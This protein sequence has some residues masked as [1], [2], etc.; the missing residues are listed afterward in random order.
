MPV[1]L[2]KTSVHRAIEIISLLDEDDL[3]MSISHLQITKK[4][5]ERFNAL[6]IYS[7]FQLVCAAK[8]H[9]ESELQSRKDSEFERC[10]SYNGYETGQRLKQLASVVRDGKVVWP[11]FWESI[12]YDFTFAA[13]RLDQAFNFDD[14]TNSLTIDTIDIGKAIFSFQDDGIH[15][16]GDLVSRLSDGLPDYRGFG[17]SKMK[18]FA[19]GLRGF[20]ST[21]NPEGTNSSLVVKAETSSPVV[22][23]N[24]V[25]R[26]TARNWPKM[27]DSAKNLTLAQIHLHKEISKL[28]RTG[29]KTLDQLFTLFESGLPQTKGIGKVARINLLKMVTCADQSITDCGEIDWDQFAKLAE[30]SVFPDSEIPLNSGSDFLACLDGIVTSLTTFCFD[31]VECAILTERLRP[32]KKAGLTLEHLGRKFRI[33]RGRVWQKQKNI[34]KSLSAGVLDDEYNGLAFRFSHRF[35][36]FWKE[37]AKH[38]C[39]TDAIPYLEF[40]QGLAEVWKVETHQIVPHLPLIYAIL[41]NNSTLPSEFNYLSSLPP[42]LFGIKSRTDLSRSFLSIHP[43]KSLA[44]AAERSGVTTI[45]QLLDVL[46]TGAFAEN[47]TIFS[48]MIE[49]LLVP[50][51]KATTPQGTISWYEFYHSKKIAYLPNLSSNSPEAFVKEAV[52]VIGSFINEAAITLR[53]NDIFRHR[54]V[55]ESAERKTLDEAGQLLGCAGPS[56]K[57]EENELLERLHDAIYSDDYTASGVHFSDA[58]VQ[59]WKKARKI[60]RQTKTQSYFAELL[61][62]E[63]DVPAENLFKIVPMMASVIEGR[64]QGY[65]GKR[66]LNL[67]TPENKAEQNDTMPLTLSVVRLRGFRYLH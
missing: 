34:V 64:P 51:A 2:E 22:N 33:C 20:I 63:W 55:P 10:W 60:Y 19:Q 37:A 42:E 43:T 13:A 54:I 46:K 6:E 8:D 29:V 47:K 11:E 9:N 28:R 16:V 35:S 24:G 15:T 21:I 41:T 36:S 52:E 62:I 30:I 61:S 27:S 59:H 48:N 44:K 14:E 49:E 17:R 67:T 66:L 3:S 18:D 26:Y 31:E 23:Y 57:R 56:I 4:S 25:L 32:S 7:L 58:F 1:S 53:S 40:I 45:G 65:T 38:F 12:D 50:L 39:Q 5:T